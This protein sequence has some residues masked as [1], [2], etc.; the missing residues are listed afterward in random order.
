MK[1]VTVYVI[2]ESEKEC[3]RKTAGPVMK[4]LK[5]IAAQLTRPGRLFLC[6]M[7][8]VTPDGVSEAKA[9]NTKAEHCNKSFNRQ[10]K[11]RP[12]FQYFRSKTDYVNGGSQSLRRGPAV[13][14]LG[15]TQHYSITASGSFQQD[16]PPWNRWKAVLFCIS[17]QSH[18]AKRKTG[19]PLFYRLS[20]LNVRYSNSYLTSVNH[21]F[22][23]PYEADFKDFFL[24]CP[25]HFVPFYFFR[26][27]LEPLWFYPYTD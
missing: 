14:H 23:Y 12:P 11:R 4:K 17:Y 22:S 9:T 10:H 6:L 7:I 5:E 19:K 8:I 25:A 13:H 26:T 1:S 27:I 16:P 20:S 15:D 2:L 21:L 3:H 24:L 18:G